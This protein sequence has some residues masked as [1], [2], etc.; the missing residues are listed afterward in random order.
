V[1]LILGEPT[2][3]LARPLLARFYAIGAEVLSITDLTSE[4][5]IVW[6]LDTALCWFE[7]HLRDG[8]TILQEQLQ[9]VIALASAN[10]DI[11]SIKEKEYSRA[12][13]RAALFAWISSLKCPVVNRFPPMFWILPRIP[14]PLWRRS[15][16]K[17]GLP[18]VD[19]VLSNV[20]TEL[21][22]FAGQFRGELNYSPLSS[23]QS[24]RVAT[25]DDFNG[26]SELTQF[27]PVNLRHH[28]P[29][30]YAACILDRNVFWN[31]SV[32]TVLINVQD[33]LV[34]LAA[35]AG[36]ALLEVTLLL[37]G[38]TPKV[39]SIE[40]FPKLDRFGPDTCEAIAGALVS[41]LRS[42]RSRCS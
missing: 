22:A 6:R 16:T 5:E 30:V 4:V 20:S 40:P 14:L 18:V 28:V 1:Y 13:K 15:L 7:L 19:A 23:Q 32:P 37:I 31:Q 26:L 27:C 34:Q 41:V 36:L 11:K 10:G 25:A 21:K 3:L 33:R 29:L 39:C 35:T 9:G 24:Y 8:R 2:T 42:D 12:E 38:D 17:C